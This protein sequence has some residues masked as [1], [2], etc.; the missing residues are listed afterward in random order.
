MPHGSRLCPHC[1]GLNGVDEKVCFRCGKS[2][3][4][5]LGAAFMG[6]FRDFTA[7]GLPMTKIIFGFCVLVYAL[8]FVLDGGQ[9]RIG[10]ANGFHDS[11]YLRLGL[12]T[13]RVPDEPWRYL[14][15]VYLHLG[16]FH[17]VMNMLALVDFGR[18]L[19]PHFG[20]ARFFL[21]YTFTGI[22]GFVIS[23]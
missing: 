5:P 10:I 14:S 21:L 12:L 8:G 3:P 16:V 15:A 9:L 2:L 11:T 19:E 17:I 1:G 6:S 23:N 20:S 7:D 22:A 4:G 13:P 18:R